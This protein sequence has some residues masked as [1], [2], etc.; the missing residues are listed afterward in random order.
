MQV[1]IKAGSLV[2]FLRSLLG[3]PGDHEV[4]GKAPHENQGCQCAGCRLSRF[5]IPLALTGDALNDAI[6]DAIRATLEAAI[7]TQKAELATAKA[8]VLEPLRPDVERILMQYRADRFAAC[9]RA[10]D[11]LAELLPEDRKPP[12]SVRLTAKSVELYL[13][14]LEASRTDVRERLA[15]KK[16]EA[17]ATAEVEAAV[18]KTASTEAGN[19]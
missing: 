6:V 12:K 18:E 15:Q 16:A 14:K 17:A 2:D 5:E 1:E 19:G 9:V 8:L 13:E 11:A 7:R 4:G 3:D 10:T